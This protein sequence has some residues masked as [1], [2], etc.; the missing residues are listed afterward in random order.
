MGDKVCFDC[1]A[2]DFIGYC[3]PDQKCK[4]KDHYRDKW[5]KYLEAVDVVCL[6]CDFEEDTCVTCPVRLTCDR[7]KRTAKTSGI[8]L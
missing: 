2:C 6:D 4:V 1:P 8:E 3:T 5:K 7:I